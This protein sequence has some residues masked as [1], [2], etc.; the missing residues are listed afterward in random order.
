MTVNATTVDELTDLTRHERR[1]D[2]DFRANVAEAEPNICDTAGTWPASRHMPAAIS[3]AQLR[4][5]IQDWMAFEN[6]QLNYDNWLDACTWD[7]VDYPRLFTDACPGTGV[8]A[9][10]AE[11]GD[12]PRRPEPQHTIPL[13]ERPP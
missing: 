8:V 4:G 9:P 12:A 7:V 13:P 2:A 5:L 1:H 6:W 10:E 3:S 11:C